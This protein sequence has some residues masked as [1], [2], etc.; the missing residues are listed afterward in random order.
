MFVRDREGH[1][2]KEAEISDA[3]RNQGT[4]RNAWP[5]QRL[6]RSEARNLPQNMGES[7]A[8]LTP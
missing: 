7:L 2:K 1:V 3:A 6:G 4:P 8:L 5:H